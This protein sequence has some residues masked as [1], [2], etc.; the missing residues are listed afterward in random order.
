MIYPALKGPMKQALNAGQYVA[1][2]PGI[3]RIGTGDT[4]LQALKTLHDTAASLGAMI[5]SGVRSQEG[6][7][8][9][10]QARTETYYTDSDSAV[11][12]ILKP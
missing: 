10:L 2:I 7:D 11:Y 6:W 3:K 9:E 1:F 4:A 12:M 5:D 8:A